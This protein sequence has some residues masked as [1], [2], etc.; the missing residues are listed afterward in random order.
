MPLLVLFKRHTR[1]A[2]KVALL[3]GTVLLVINQL[4]ALLG[5][6]EIRWLPAVLTYCVPFFVFLLGKWSA[7]GPRKN[8][9]E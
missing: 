4:D 5:H 3:V 7:G 1:Q 8:A 9:Q 6:D 2:I